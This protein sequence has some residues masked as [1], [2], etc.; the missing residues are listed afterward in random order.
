MRPFLTVSLAF[1][2]GFAVVADEPKSADE[3]KK[4]AID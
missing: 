4:Q 2:F 3:V 1:V